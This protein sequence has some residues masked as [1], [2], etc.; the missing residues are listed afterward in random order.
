MA[1]FT[2]SKES[3]NLSL[4]EVAIENLAE[5]S[6]NSNNNENEKI[7]ISE[8]MNEL[9]LVLNRLIE[10]LDEEK[11]LKTSLDELNMNVKNIIENDKI[12]SSDLLNSITLEL[13][14]LGKQIDKLK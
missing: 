1:I 11:K 14:A 7:K 3:G 8:K 9:N 4:S 5:I 2:A 10:K 12:H 6:K 13:R